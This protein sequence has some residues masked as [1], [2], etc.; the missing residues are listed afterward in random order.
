MEDG[1]NPAIDE[2]WT[3]SGNNPACDCD[4][5]PDKLHPN[6]CWICGWSSRSVAE[7]MQQRCLKAHITRSKHSWKKKRAHITA[8]KDVEQ[9]KRK[10]NQDMLPHVYWDIKKVKNSWTFTYLG[11]VFRP[12]GDHIQDV[13]MRVSMATVRSGKLRNIWGADLPLKLK[14]RFYKSACCSILVWV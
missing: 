12:D 9:K 7:T 3:S 4:Y 1:C 10:A 2:Y 11:S 8:Q 13:K 6:R 5:Y 14:L